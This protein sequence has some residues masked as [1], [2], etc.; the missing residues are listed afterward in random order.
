MPQPPKTR[1]AMPRLKV[2]SEEPDASSTSAAE[3]QQQFKGLKCCFNALINSYS[4]ETERQIMLH[5]L[6]VIL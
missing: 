2:E 1:T 3:T 4:A 5:R 6:I